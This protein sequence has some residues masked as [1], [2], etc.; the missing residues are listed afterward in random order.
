M[1]ERLKVREFRE[2]ERDIE[3][4]IESVCGSGAYSVKLYSTHIMD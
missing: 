2:S 4:M 1:R 3:K